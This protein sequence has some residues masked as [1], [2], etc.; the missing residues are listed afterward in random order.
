MRRLLFALTF[1]LSP[2]AFA[3]TTTVTGTLAPYAN[4]TAYAINQC[5]GNQTQPAILSG[6]GAFSLVVANGCGHI[7]TLNSPPGVPSRA[8]FSISLPIYTGGTV[9][10]SSALAANAPTP[11]STGGSTITCASANGIVYWSGTAYVCSTSVAASQL[12]FIGD[13]T[14]R[15]MNVVAPGTYLFIASGVNSVFLTNNEV[16]FLAGSVLR[17]TSSTTDVTSGSPDFSISHPAA[18]SVAFGNGTPNDATAA[19]AGG[20]AKFAAYTTATVCTSVTAPA[21][22][23]AAMAG[24]V[25]VAAAGTAITINSTAITA[26]TGCWFTYTIEGITAP[27]N[28][29]SLLSPYVSA[30]TPGTSITLTLPVAPVAN[31]VNLNFGCVN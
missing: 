27:T 8:A 17:W 23:G 10:V 15:I 3:Q 1:C 30:R 2:L 19:V 26:S 31:P 25:Q 7:L 9:D 29:A 21:A 11:P 18:N 13:P 6:S 4:S 5:T 12:G 14:T 28:I 20:T 16:R 22:C 24:K